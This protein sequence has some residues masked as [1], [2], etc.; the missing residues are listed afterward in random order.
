MRS[1]ESISSLWVGAE[2]RGELQ[3]YLGKH[4]WGA[5]DSTLW[6]LM[7]YPLKFV[8]RE[9]STTLDDVLHSAIRWGLAE[10]WASTELPQREVR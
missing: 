2:C 3:R 10:V 7:R 6:A 5:V 9:Y 1:V 4:T 8:I